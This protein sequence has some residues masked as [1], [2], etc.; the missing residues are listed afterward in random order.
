[1]G[2]R[3]SETKITR[4]SHRRTSRRARFLLRPQ[5]HRQD[6]EQIQR[7]HGRHRQGTGTIRTIRAYMVVCAVSIDQLRPRRIHLSSKVRERELLAIDFNFT[8]PIFLY[9]EE[10]IHVDQA[11]DVLRS[12]V[13]FGDD[14]QRCH[15]TVVSHRRCTDQLRLLRPAEILQTE[16]QA[17]ATTGWQVT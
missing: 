12:A 9:A 11:A 3:Q 6:P 7:R 4:G 5:S 13:R 15:L 17:I 2:R 8:S 16:R 10:N 1:M 14:R